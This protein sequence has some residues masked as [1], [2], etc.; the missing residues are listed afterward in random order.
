[1][2]FVTPEEFEDF[3]RAGEEM[4]FQTVFSA[5]LVVRP[6]STPLKFFKKYN[7]TAEIAENAELK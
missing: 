1:M 3:R 6:P 5:P 2:R 4:G 7:F